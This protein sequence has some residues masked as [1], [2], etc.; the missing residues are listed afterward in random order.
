MADIP[1]PT[2]LKVARAAYDCWLH[3]ATTAPWPHEVTQ[4]TWVDVVKVV[5]DELGF[6]QYRPEEW[7]PKLGSVWQDRDGHRWL[8][9]HDVGYLW[10][11]SS[12]ADDTAEE[13]WDKY[14][15]MAFVM[16]IDPTEQEIPW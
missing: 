8:C 4:A 16:Q 12:P 7:P 9:A 2:V 14:G 13:I 6:V 11:I 15:P 3:S 1:R 5:A 10:R